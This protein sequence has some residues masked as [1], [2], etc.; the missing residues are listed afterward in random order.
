MCSALCCCCAH[1]GTRRL[2]RPLVCHLRNIFEK[3]FAASQCRCESL[4]ITPRDDG[5]QAWHGH[6]ITQVP[7]TACGRSP[8][9]ACYGL[10]RAAVWCTYLPTLPNCIADAPFCSP[11]LLE[12]PFPVSQD[13]DTDGTWISN[14]GFLRKL[15]LLQCPNR[16]RRTPTGVPPSR[17]KRGPSGQTERVRRNAENGT[18]ARAQR[19]TGNS[20]HWQAERGAE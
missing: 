7:V 15:V 9:P 12:P 13:A 18:S 3:R 6:R 4:L 5:S 11:F 1:F 16:S 20:A 17:C 8:Q 2:A 14:Q 19:S 10:Y